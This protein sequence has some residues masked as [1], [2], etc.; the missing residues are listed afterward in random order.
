[1]ELAEDDVTPKTVIPVAVTIAGSDPYGGAGLKPVLVKGGRL[2]NHCET[3]VRRRHRQQS[4]MR[5]RMQINMTNASTPASCLIV[6]EVRG[7]RDLLQSW[8]VNDGFKV[9]MA[10]D[11]AEAWEMIQQ[12]PPGFIVTDIEMPRLSGLELIQR[13][14][15]SESPTI[16]ATPILAMTS[17][18]DCKT[19]KTVQDLGGNGLLVKPLDKKVVDSVLL[20]LLADRPSGPESTVDDRVHESSGA[21][22]ISPA[23]RRL[24]DRVALG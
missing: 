5:K 1:L 11:G 21:G 17:L 16:H 15:E 23:L 6:D 19:L 8:M 7:S 3:R 12:S 24:L 9:S 2:G 10:K 20:N 18:H 4:E 22:V 14:R 13:V